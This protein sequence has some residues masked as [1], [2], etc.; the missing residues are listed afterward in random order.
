VFSPAAGGAGF[1][2]KRNKVSQTSSQILLLPETLYETTPK[3]HGFLRIKRAAFQAR[4]GAHMRLRLAGT[5]KRLNVEHRTSNIERR[6]L[7]ALR[8][9]ESKTVE[10]QNFEEWFLSWPW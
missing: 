3:W 9:I 8:F 1:I 7:M 2:K 5:A 4:G 6:I 10:S